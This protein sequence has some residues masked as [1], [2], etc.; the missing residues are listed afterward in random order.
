MSRDGPT[1][2]PRRRDRR[3]GPSLF[4]LVPTEAWKALYHEDVVTMEELVQLSEDERAR[5]PAAHSLAAVCELHGL[6]R[7]VQV[8]GRWLDSREGIGNR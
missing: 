6:D 2:A 5:V 7:E 3:P 8:L 4:P 1:C